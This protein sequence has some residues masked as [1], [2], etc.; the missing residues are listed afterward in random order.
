MKKRKKEEHFEIEVSYTADGRPFFDILKDSFFQYLKDLRVNVQNNESHM[1]LFKTYLL[2][3]N[4]NR[5]ISF[6]LIE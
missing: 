4:C 3:F 2:L 6:N 5:K 1:W